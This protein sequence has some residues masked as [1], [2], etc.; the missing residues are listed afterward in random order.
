MLSKIRQTQK[1]KGFTI[2]EVLIVL[3]IAGLIL[4]VVFLAVPALQRNARNTQR[5]E[6]AGNI[7]SAISEYVG[8]NNGQLPAN[9][10]TGGTGSALTIGASGSNTVPVNLG[11]YTAANVSIAT[12]ASGNTNTTTTDTITVM[13]GAVCSTTTT[14]DPASGSSRS[15][16]ILY[17]LETASKQCR[18]S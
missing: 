12:F 6:D 3:A 9:G 5:T 14:G 1:E 4:L 18:A 16:V 17:T 8:N 2:I 7:L 10:G 15:V 13:K 11:Y